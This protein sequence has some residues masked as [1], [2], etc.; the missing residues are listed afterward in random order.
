MT[1]SWRM[2]WIGISVIFSYQSACN[3]TENI[4]ERAS[5]TVSGAPVQSSQNEDDHEPESTEGTL[6]IF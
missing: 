5:S 1:S 3:S 4:N 2:V 6:E